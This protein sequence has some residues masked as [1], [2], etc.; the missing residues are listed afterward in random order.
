MLIK[1]L[2]RRFTER[3]EGK[4][5]V[6]TRR[7]NIEVPSSTFTSGYPTP[8]PGSVVSGS[9]GI[10]KRTSRRISQI[11][12]EYNSVYGSKALRFDNVMIENL[13]SAEACLNEDSTSVWL[14]W[15]RMQSIICS[16]DEDSKE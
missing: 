12:V 5:A 13:D 7:Q 15:L 6:D 9:I 4:G 11:I 2:K 14:S 10:L 1:F 3:H 16:D 8:G